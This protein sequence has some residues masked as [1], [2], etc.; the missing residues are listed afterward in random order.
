MPVIFLFIDGVGLGN[1]AE[2]NPLIDDSLNG[3]SFMSAGKPFAKSAGPVIRKNHLFIPVDATLG[4]EGLPQSG[5]GQAALFSGSNA[6]K[7]IGKHFGPYP[8]SGVKPLLKEQSLFKKAGQKRAQCTFINAYPDI[9][10]QKAKKR[11]RWTCTTLMAK[12]AGISLKTE[13][14]VKNGTALTAD[15]TQESWRQNLNIDIP[16]ITPEEAAE[17]LIKQSAHFGLLLHEYYLTD[18]AGHSRQKETANKYIRRYDDFLWTLIQLKSPETTLV[19]CSDHG[20]VEDLS[21]KTHTFNKVPLFVF[22]PGAQ[23]FHQPKSIM[24]V[25]PGIL[26]VLG[27]PKQRFF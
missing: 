13:Q 11:S 3:F 10:F 26:D 15:L 12:S 9:F 27:K 23:A 4:I 2:E 5:T 17:R 8:H 6:A 1:E 22:G 25:T 19:L 24:D 18:K 20:N 7:M 16:L 21:T 14:D